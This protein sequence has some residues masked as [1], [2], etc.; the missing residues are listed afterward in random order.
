MYNELL[1]TVKSKMKPIDGLNLAGMICD[2]EAALEATQLLRMIYDCDDVIKKTEDGCVI[3]L[4]FKKGSFN[5]YEGMTF[6]AL[7]IWERIFY[8]DF[9]L[10]HIKLEDNSITFDAITIPRGNPY[11]FHC[12]IKVKCS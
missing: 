3:D 2:V 7:E 6:I 10:S 9:Q 5:S 8:H 11:Y 1:K 12:I 4:N